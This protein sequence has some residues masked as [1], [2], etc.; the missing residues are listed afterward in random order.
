MESE[1]TGLAKMK[2]SNLRH[3]RDVVARR[4]ELTENQRRMIIT[5]V[6]DRL[7]SRDPVARLPEFIRQ[8]QLGIPMLEAAQR[9][10]SELRE[11]SSGSDADTVSKSALMF[12]LNKYYNRIPK[13]EVDTGVNWIIDTIIKELDTL[14]SV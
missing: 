5:L 10:L 13:N 8:L 2:E 4:D 12:I 9:E 14:H 6:D 1:V 7:E 3:L 11:L